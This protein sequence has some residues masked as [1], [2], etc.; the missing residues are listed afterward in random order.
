VALGDG[1]TVLGALGELGLLGEPPGKPGMG[2]S[3]L[4]CPDGRVPGAVAV[5][6][7]A[8][9]AGRVAVLSSAAPD[10]EQPVRITARI[11]GWQLCFTDFT[12]IPCLDAAR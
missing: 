2:V 12:K 10:V 6:V 11:Q 9:L 5:L 8:P 1:V 4:A 7:G 3:S